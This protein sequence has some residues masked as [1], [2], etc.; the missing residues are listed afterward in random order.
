MKKNHQNFDV[1]STSWKN[2]HL[3]ILFLL[4]PSNQASGLIFST[5]YDIKNAM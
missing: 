3:G 2:S 4:L 5:S 1:E